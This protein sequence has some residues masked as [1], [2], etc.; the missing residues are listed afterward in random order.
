[1]GDWI[2][3]IVFVLIVIG[4]LVGLKMLSKPQTRT[5][6]E[7]ERNAAEG[8]TALGAS[9]N[10]LQ[11]LMNPEAAKSKEVITQMKDG[12]YQKKKREG[13]ADSNDNDRESD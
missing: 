10:A 5:S 3:L 1:M 8:T 9:M 2:G 12:R 6:E 7:F 11:E 13:K 4:A